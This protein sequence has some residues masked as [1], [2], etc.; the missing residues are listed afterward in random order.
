MAICSATEYR[1]YTNDLTSYDGWVDSALEDAQAEVERI[2]DRSFEADVAY[3]E[4]TPPLHFAAYP[5]EGVGIDSYG[6]QY[7]LSAAATTY[8]IT[9]YEPE[10]MP[11]G[12]KRLVAKIANLM[13]TPATYENVPLGATSI[14]VG[15]ISISGKNLMLSAADVIDG[16]TYREIRQ[17]R[18]GNE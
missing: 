8:T 3:E 13:L 4:Y 10:T 15:D 6:N 2:S 5:G 1:R 12:L 16:A 9:A 18:R 17:W 14:S 11:V 7:E